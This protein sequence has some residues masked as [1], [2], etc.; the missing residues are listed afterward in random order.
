MTDRWS[1]TER[2]F[3]AAL[4]RPVEA[5]AA[6]VAEACGDDD[7]LRRNVLSLLDGASAA[8]F[9]EQPAMQI[10][11]GLVTSASLAPLTGQR[12]GVYSIT[13]LLGRG[14]MGEV[15]RAR[16]TRLGR[17]VAI[18]VLPRALTADPERLARFE[19]EARMLAS[20]NHPHIGMLFRLEESGGHCA[21]ILELIEGETLAERLAHG[22]VALK[23]ALNWARQIADALDAAHEKGIVHRDLKPANVKITP[24]DVVKV[25][26][27]GLARTFGSNVDS[28]QPRAPTIT[29][30]GA[31]IVGTAAYMSPEQARG[32]PVDR[33]TDVWAFGCLLYE[34]LTGRA[35]F[36]RLTVTDTLAAVLNDQPDWTALPA[37]LPPAV[38]TVLRRCLE[39]DVRRRRRDIGDVGAE[40]DDAL[41]ASETARAKSAAVMSSP[42]P[43]ARRRALMLALAGVVTGAA[44]VAVADRWMAVEPATEPSSAVRLKRITDG[45]GIEEMPAVSRDGKE[46]AFVAR[47]VN[48]MRQIF[49]RKLAGGGSLQITSD[50]V[51]HDHPRWTHDASHIV[52]F[53][54]PLKE[55][56]LGSL[57]QVPALGGSLRKLDESSTGA[58]VSPDGRWLATF[59]KNAAGTALM[60]LPRDHDAQRQLLSIETDRIGVNPDLH[61]PRWSPDGR[62]VAFYIGKSAWRYELFVADVATGTIAS[63]KQSKHIKGVAWLPGGDGVVFASSAGSTMLY[64]PV[65]TLFSLSLDRSHERQLTVGDGSFEQPDIVASGQLFASRTLGKSDVWRFPVAGSPQEN[66]R[67]ATQITRQTGQVQTPS[68]SPDGREIAYLSDTGG[69]SNIWIASTDGSENPRPLT[70]ETDDRVIIGIPIWSPLDGRIAFIGDD[71]RIPDMSGQTEWLINRDGSE[72]RQ[73]TKGSSAAWSADGQLLY[74]Q[75]QASEDKPQCIYKVRVDGTAT[76]D[77]VRC[78]AAVPAPASDGTL[79]FVKRGFWNANE[80][81]RAKPE[82]AESSVLVARYDLSR[83]PLWPTGFALSPDGR[84]LAVPLKDNGTTNIWL[85]PTDG[86]L[87]RQITDF[88]Q[89]PTLIARQVSWS[90]DGKFIYAAVAETDSDIVLLEGGAA[91]R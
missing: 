11:A 76:P 42:P 50:D 57:W 67:N 21:L 24:E 51:D 49:V 30:E 66:V 25:L 37:T 15:Y 31:G 29:I 90:R 87:H 28:D 48:G 80:I 3:H 58:D 91:G 12:I 1:A 4:E 34:L 43:H 35:A 70:T 27:F 22:P 45:V 61:P 69:H 52:Y 79:Y 20:L 85:I 86:G 81:Y 68:V 62:K 38:T 2:I 13:A 39:K 17:E 72:R 88:G 40:L 5:R 23:Q 78:D 83:V 82:H 74:Y 65:F 56:E 84:W 6:F 33:R 54:P 89:R 36:L 73:L 47:G 63:L 41:A 19:R 71:T 75:S 60:I 64:P 55:A 9:L 10:A 32:Q 18:K 26:D 46:L 14:G 44:L 77:R 53:T 7:E 8:G 16:D 59:R